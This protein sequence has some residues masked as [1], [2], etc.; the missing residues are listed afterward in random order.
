MPGDL[1]GSPLL[2]FVPLDMPDG[3]TPPR[4]SLAAMMARRF[5]SYKTHVV[6]PFFRD[7]FIRLDRQ[8]VLV[9]ALTALN[10]GSAAVGELT[11]ALEASL[12]VFRPGPKSWLG[13]LLGRRIDRIL[14][15][16]AKADHLSQS[17]HDRLE[18]VLR[19]MTEKA[20]ARAAFAGAEVKV[21]VLAAVRA[22]REVEAKQ[23]ADR[24]PCIR[25]VPMAGERI[26]AKLFDG[27]TEV[28]I[29]PGDLPEDPRS[30]LERSE[31]TA[32]RADLQFVR[33]RPPRLAHTTGNAEI[34][35]WPHIRLDRALDY[36]IGDRLA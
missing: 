3:W 18:A 26:G 34:Q 21:L 14:Y 30:M 35:P 33:F 25:G 9:D 19:L 29:F 12:R 7:H 13:P 31:P 22:T 4:G 28:A 16:A 1:E 8:I 32:D 5:A 24:L 36:L 27:Q 20:A 2:T 15:A 23:G 11:R 6:K 10:A 17:S